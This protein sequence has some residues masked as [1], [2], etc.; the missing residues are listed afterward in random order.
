MH[1]LQLFCSISL[2]KLLISVITSLIIHFDSF[3]VRPQAHNIST[4]AGASMEK[5]ISDKK[6]L[7]ILI[8][9]SLI[10]YIF[11]LW[12]LLYR[13][14]YIFYLLQYMLIEK[15]HVTCMYEMKD[16]TIIK[17]WRFGRAASS[18]LNLLRNPGA[19]PRVESSSGN[20]TFVSL[21]AICYWIVF[22][23]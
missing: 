11:F 17:I 16:N 22:W 18:V 8:F 12:I 20:C 1:I 13:R 6:F 19:V 10:A 5:F 21:N 23:W 14:R 7:N 2:F 4:C 3:K 15:L 9:D